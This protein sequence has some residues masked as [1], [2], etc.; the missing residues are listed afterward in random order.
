VGKG[1]D[2]VGYLGPAPR[3]KA[4]AFFARETILARRVRVIAFAGWHR[5]WPASSTAVRR[6]VPQA[7][8]TAMEDARRRYR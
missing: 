2:V 5:G 1:P 6:D 4:A 3:P 8:L 7:S